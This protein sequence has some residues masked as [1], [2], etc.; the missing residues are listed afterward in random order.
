MFDWAAATTPRV[1]RNWA[2]KTHAWSFRVVGVGDAG[3]RV[4]A[5]SRIRQHASLGRQSRH[6]RRSQVGWQRLDPR[7]AFPT[8]TPLVGG[9]SM[10]RPLRKMTEDRAPPGYTRLR[11]LRLR[12]RSHPAHISREVAGDSRVCPPNTHAPHAKRP[13]H[14]VIPGN[15]RGARRNHDRPCM[16]VIPPFPFLHFVRGPI[17]GRGVPLHLDDRSVSEQR[18]IA[19]E[20]VELAPGTDAGSGARHVAGAGSRRDQWV[21]RA[22]EVGYRNIETATAYG[23]EEQVGQ[24]VAES[25]CRARR[26]SSRRS[27]RRVAQV[28]SERHSKTDSTRW[29]SGTSTCGSSM[30]A[31]RWRSTGRMGAVAR[32][33]GG[34]ARTRGWRQQLQLRQ[35]D[36]LER[37]TGRL[38]AVNQIER[39]PALFD[40]SVLEGHRRRGV[41]SRGIAR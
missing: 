11:W 8:K 30:A 40:R 35:L 19:E 7:G 33:A 32:A 28:V 16:P 5:P 6:S 1:A 9:S 39:S 18:P 4:V 25:A 12:Q 38:P 15:S 14:G 36:E 24:A 20:S 34:R 3:N 13:A 2:S 31:Q 21:L 37:A 27:C 23:N 22:P 41:Q 29:G 10:L 17:W 26:S